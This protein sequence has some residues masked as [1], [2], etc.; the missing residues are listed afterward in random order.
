MTKQASTAGRTRKVVALI[1]AATTSAGGNLV[2]W[3]Q[4][5]HSHVVGS[6]HWMLRFQVI[7]DPLREVLATIEITEP[8]QAWNMGAITPAPAVS[9][10]LFN[11]THAKEITLT[12]P[13]ITHDPQAEGFPPCRILYGADSLHLVS[14]EYFDAVTELFPNQPLILR[15]TE[16][17]AVITIGN[18]LA[19][20]LPIQLHGESGDTLRRFMKPPLAV[21]VKMGVVFKGA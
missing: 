17:T 3:T 6:R 20:L 4:H 5:E 14:H 19:V 11:W 7:P 8:G 18:A 2:Y 13:R 21:D 12:D 9:K 16:H 10:L 15:Q 1:K